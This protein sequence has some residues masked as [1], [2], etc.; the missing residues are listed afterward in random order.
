MIIKK[1]SRNRDSRRK[2]L[3]LLENNQY[4][5]SKK[6]SKL[7]RPYPRAAKRNDRNNNPKKPGLHK[8]LKGVN[9]NDPDDKIY[10]RHLYEFMLTLSTEFTDLKNGVKAKLLFKKLEN[11]LTKQV[12]E[13]CK[14]YFIK[15]LNR[16]G[17][18]NGGEALNPNFEL[19]GFWNFLHKQKVIT[20][21][22]LNFLSS[23]E[24]PDMYTSL[25]EVKSEVELIAFVRTN[26]ADQD[27]V[28]EALIS[29]MCKALVRNQDNRNLGRNPLA[30]ST[31]SYEDFIVL[32]GIG[33]AE[34]VFKD[35]RILFEVMMRIVN[36][37]GFS[38]LL[39]EKTLERN[40]IRLYNRIA[41]MTHPYAKPLEQ[42][43]TIY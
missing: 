9:N 8:S 22:D 15:L 11:V 23:N 37:I 36:N 10:Y 24:N 26:F 5:R 41:H 31:S 1:S 39:A 20:D 33:M 35:M 16:Y 32:H 18:E 27:V 19:D 13:L 2:L 40:R 21:A 17:T 43:V 28:A 12:I 38:N 25:E 4:L 29:R 14:K 3:N 6:S 34:F 30:L 42:P 7:L